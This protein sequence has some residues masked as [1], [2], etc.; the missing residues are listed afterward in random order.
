VDVGEQELPEGILRGRLAEQGL[1][2]MLSQQRARVAFWRE[3]P[4]V[5]AD[6]PLFSMDWSAPPDWLTY[7]RDLRTSDP[8]LFHR[9]LET[10]QAWRA[11]RSDSLLMLQT[12][13]AE[14]HRLEERLR[15]LRRPTLHA[16]ISQM[17]QLLVDTEQQLS[18]THHW[19]VLHHSLVGLVMRLK[20]LYP[21]CRTSLDVGLGRRVRNGLLNLATETG[22]NVVGIE[23]VGDQFINT[24]L[25]PPHVKG[26]LRQLITRVGMAYAQSQGAAL[27]APAHRALRDGGGPF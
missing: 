20:Q 2:E 21:L 5:A 24:L 23:P 22:A 26:L 13:E 4:A 18:W 9:G 6:L 14:V 8:A 17:E 7:V 16:A 12:A 25:S 10:V 19:A 27:Q 11:L 3:F 1:T 15:S